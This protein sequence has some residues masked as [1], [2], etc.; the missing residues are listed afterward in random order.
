MFEKLYLIPGGFLR[1]G[2]FLGPKTQKYKSIT[3]LSVDFYR[4]LFD[5]RHWKRNFQG[6]YDYT[7]RTPLWAFLGKNWFASY[8]LFHCFAF[9]NSF[10][11]RTGDPLLLRSCSGTWVISMTASWRVFYSIFSAHF[12]FST[13]SK[14]D[15]DTVWNAWCNGTNAWRKE[16]TFSSFNQI[17]TVCKLILR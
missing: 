8:F 2:K 11:F 15:T 16:E 5:D 17:N 9:P 13:C 6:K 3:K 7:Q 14:L 1:N 4:N 10:L 12:I